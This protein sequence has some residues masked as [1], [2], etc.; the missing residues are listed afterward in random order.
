MKN[1]KK[2]SEG[3]KMEKQKFKN[4]STFASLI[5]ILLITIV[6]A[7]TIGILSSLGVKTNKKVSGLTTNISMIQTQIQAIDSTYLFTGELSG[8]DQ[9]IHLIDVGL[10][11]IKQFY[12][13]TNET[14]E[15]AYY[16]LEA[17]ATKYISVV[18]NGEQNNFKDA[19]QNFLTSLSENIQLSKEISR[20]SSQ[21]NEVA[22]TIGTIFLIIFSTISLILVF[23]I[24]K[25]QNEQDKIIKQKDDAIQ[26]KNN[27]ISDIVYSDIITQLPNKYAMIEKIETP[28]VYNRATGFVFLEGFANLKTTYGFNVCDII[29]TEIV[30]ALNNIKDYQF[31]MIDDETFGFTYDTNDPITS[32][33]ANKIKNK[34]KVNIDKNYFIENQLMITLNSRVC[35]GIIKSKEKVSFDTLYVELSKE[36]YKY[37]QMSQMNGSRNI[38]N[39][40]M[41]NN[42][43][44]R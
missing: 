6:S 15:T 14:E 9:Y 20:E 33:V 32:A 30:N 35:V 26:K 8:T 5:C 19:R 43:M 21:K 11:Q 16:N 2:E 40:S 27:V 7:S 23:V 29:R 28:S 44:Y 34:I 38:V 3:T 41:Y 39:S 24:N 12:D 37:S 4:K 31:Y 22:R 18:E 25:K 1:F 13:F 17:Y 36:K 10:S 42:N